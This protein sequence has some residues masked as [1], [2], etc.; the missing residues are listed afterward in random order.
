MVSSL[1]TRMF[2]SQGR[3]YISLS[4]VEPYTFQISCEWQ[5]PSGVWVESVRVVVVGHVCREVV[6]CTENAPH[7]WELDLLRNLD[8]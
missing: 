5:D 1:P 8:H 3:M 2:H 7:C 6:H 4:C